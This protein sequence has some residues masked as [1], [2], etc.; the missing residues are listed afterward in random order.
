M[1]RI[2]FSAAVTKKHECTQKGA[3]KIVR[4]SLRNTP[5]RVRRLEE[6]RQAAQEESY[7]GEIELENE[8]S[9]EN[10]RFT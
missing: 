8:E 6:N 5:S 1:E 9:Y 2:H 10:L 3:Q 4:N 7:P